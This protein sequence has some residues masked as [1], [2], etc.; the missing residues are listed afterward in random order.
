MLLSTL[1]LKKSLWIVIREG[2]CQNKREDEKKFAKRKI[3]QRRGIIAKRKKKKLKEIGVE[4]QP[5]L[6]ILGRESYR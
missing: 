6:A 3:C 2:S 5:K 1:S 4:I